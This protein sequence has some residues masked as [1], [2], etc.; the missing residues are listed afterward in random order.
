MRNRRW[1][2]WLAMVTLGLSLFG[3]MARAI[4]QQTVPPK[5]VENPEKPKYSGKDA[6]ELIFKQELSIPL[7]GGLYSFDVD[8][9]GNIY[10]L[11][12]FGAIV[13][14]YDK[15]GKIIAKFGKKGQGPGEFGNPVCL[16]LSKNKRIHVLDRSTKTVQIFDLNGNPLDHQ[17]LGSV[18]VLNSLSFD[19]AGSAYIQHM[20]TRAALREGKRLGPQALGLSCLSRFDSRFNKVADVYTWEDSF[21]RR[22]PD[23]D[24]LYVLYHDVFCYQLDS[25]DSLYYGHS[26]AYEIRQM[27]LQG[28]VTRIIKKK[29]K[30]IPTVH[31]DFTCILE[32]HPDLEQAKDLIRMSDSKPL[33]ADFHILENIGLLVGTYED[34][35]NEDGVLLCDLFDQNGVYVARITAPRYYL[36]SQ[37]GVDWEKR[38]RLFKNGK[39]YSIVAV[40]KGEALALVRHSF[41]L[42]WPLEKRPKLS[43]QGPR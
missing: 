39:C 42:R 37:H 13:T 26:S 18:G 22:S 32:E 3:F 34:E 30:R 43:D 1:L 36:W 17:L 4:C 15:D 19:S 41:E 10:L 29:A 23:R 11:D 21:R 31:K 7:E 38:N 9:A 27:T 25:D 24:V 12:I 2:S 33:F 14:V 16:A 28:Q 6:P 20:L 8:D 35:W 40:E 5:V